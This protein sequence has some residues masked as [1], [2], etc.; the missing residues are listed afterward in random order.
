[1]QQYDYDCVGVV[2]GGSWGTTIAHLLGKSGNKVLLWLRDPQLIETINRQHQNPKYTETMPLSEN[3]TAI[4]DLQQLA[5]H[6]AI[7]FVTVPSH[8]FRE[9]AYLL[10]NY[11][12]G[13]QIIISGCKGLEANTRCRMT[14]IIQEETCVK[15]IGVLAGPNLYKEILQESPCATV[16][17]SHYNEV[18]QSGRQLFRLP[19][20]KIY[21]SEDILGVEL[22]SVIQNVIA[23]AAGIVD[24][25]GFGMSTKAMLLTRGM[26]EMGR[27]GNRMGA[28]PLTFTG[29]SGLGD[30]VVG[31]CSRLSQDYLVG[32]GLS[33]G[34]N[35]G[36]ILEE[37][38]AA[39][40]GINACKVLYEFTVEERLD[41]PIVHGV[42]QIVHQNKSIRD[43]IADLMK[44][45]FQ[46]EIDST[47]FGSLP[48]SHG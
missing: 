32:Y 23:I 19:Y 9:V 7:I 24:G 4:G 10:G 2:G 42:Y 34:K 26:I 36:Q 8:G 45:N 28:D 43:V 47:L 41:V 22:G 12:T 20:F 31:C 15:K 5:Q 3:I 16:L 33:Q 14:S 37:T 48:K 25:L 13:D 30:M 46:F 38:K 18:I 39:A 35:L 29:L 40:E 17:A 44:R 6:C 21:G 11:V 27:V 1:M